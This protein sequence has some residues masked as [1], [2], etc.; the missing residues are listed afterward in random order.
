MRLKSS[1]ELDNTQGK[2]S[3]L[4][5]LIEKKEQT[6][7]NSP[8]YHASLDSMRKTA[9]KLRAEIN[10]YEAAHQPS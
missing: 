10:E 5:K 3:E 7:T 6:P 8:A 1:D 9:Q 4:L 2:L